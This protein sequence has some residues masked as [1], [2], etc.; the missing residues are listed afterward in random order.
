MP[1]Y[2]YL[3]LAFRFLPYIGS[4]LYMFLLFWIIPCYPSYRKCFKVSG[5]HV[6]SALLAAQVITALIFCFCYGRRWELVKTVPLMAVISYVDLR[7]QEIPDLPTVLMILLNF[8]RRSTE[9]NFVLAF[10]MLVPLTVFAE[11]GSIGYGDVKLICAYVFLRG[12]NALIGLIIGCLLCLAVSKLKKESP[13]AKIPFGP[14]I[15]A[16]MFV[17]LFLPL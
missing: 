5:I 6:V 17:M 14:Y 9:L 11:K 15:C 4:V 13:K 8:F 1:F 3:E 16:G 10:L 12:H 7:D 2:Y